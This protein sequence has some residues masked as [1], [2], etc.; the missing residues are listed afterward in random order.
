MLMV[1][2]GAGASYDSS[3]TYTIGMQ[4][5]D[6]ADPNNKENRPP[7]AKDLFE[8]RPLFIR[9]VDAFP[10]CRSIVPRFRDP[11]VLAG[12]KSLE[13]LLQDLEGEAQTYNR[14]KKEL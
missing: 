2:F 14:G 10:Q 7:L 4:P 8:N 6:E 11:A 1:I 9:A 3:P 12:Q 13:A 5:P